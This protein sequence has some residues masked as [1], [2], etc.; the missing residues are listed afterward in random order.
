M[1]IRTLQAWAVAFATAF[2]ASAAQATPIDAEVASVAGPQ[3]RVVNN[4]EYRVQVVLVDKSG[5]HHT[6]GHVAPHKAA[7]YDVEVFADY[8]LPIQVK[9]VVDEPAWSPGATDKAVRTG[10]LYVSDQTEVRVWVESDLTK[11]E[12]E[13]HRW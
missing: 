10:S 12:V 4:H 11:T 13:V 6:L 5:R 9:V 3:L 8:G 2:S 7:A 1:K